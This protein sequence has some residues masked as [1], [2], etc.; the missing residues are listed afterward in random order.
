METSE[1]TFKNRHG[2]WLLMGI[3]GWSLFVCFL[4]GLCHSVSEP[5]PSSPLPGWRD[6][7]LHLMSAVAFVRAANRPFEQR[8]RMINWSVKE[9]ELLPSG[10]SSPINVE[11]SSHQ[12]QASEP[13]TGRH[14]LT[15][16]YV[17]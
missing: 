3:D 17:R 10:P 12:R 6:A 7:R 13:D 8:S 5:E 2:I 11:R 1:G 14:D 9:A 4:S 15:G 16:T